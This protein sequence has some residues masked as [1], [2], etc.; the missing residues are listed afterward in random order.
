MQ[1]CTRPAYTY[2]DLLYNVI[3]FTAQAV[4][5]SQ[6]SIGTSQQIPVTI[7]QQQVAA[8]STNGECFRHA[9]CTYISEHYISEHIWK[10]SLRLWSH[11]TKCIAKL[12][13]CDICSP[14]YKCNDSSELSIAS[15]YLML[16]CTSRIAGSIGRFEGGKGALPPKLTSCPLKAR[17]YSVL[18]FAT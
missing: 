4:T 16:S 3:Y 7:T 11:P 10:K 2:G 8:S 18:C 13:I 6:H 17:Q 1:L 14:T 12:I 5:S 9:S 15:P